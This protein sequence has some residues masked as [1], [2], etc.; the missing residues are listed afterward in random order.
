MQE[1]PLIQI[2]N[3]QFSVELEARQWTITIKEANGVMIA[4]VNVDGDDVV[5]GT[6]ILAGEPIIPYGYLQDGNLVL[7]TLDDALPYWDQFGVSQA[8]VYLT[9]AEMA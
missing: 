4:D 6:R 2:A 5:T 7:V 3:Q 1:L 9:N 8:L